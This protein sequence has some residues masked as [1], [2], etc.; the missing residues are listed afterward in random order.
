MKLDK[1]NDKRS[2]K[3][4]QLTEITQDSSTDDES[5]KTK[6][7]QR[8]EHFKSTHFNFNFYKRFRNSNLH[9]YFIEGDIGSVEADQCVDTL[10]LVNALLL[11]VP[12]QALAY[13]SN[14]YWDWIESELESCTDVSHYKYYDFDYIYRSTINSF[15]VLTFASAT[16]LSIAAFYYILRPKEEVI[17]SYWWNRGCR[18]VIIVMMLTSIASCWATMSLFL[19]FINTYPLSSSKFCEIYD[20]PS[21]NYLARNNALGVAFMS[22]I[23]LL[24][25]IVMI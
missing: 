25:M 6:V 21:K 22:F 17:F 7:M 2:Q 16:A 11:T 5:R 14:I 8:I 18:W 9:K 23:V 12:F 13:A 15:Y 24:S 20:E 3:P 10:A 1:I 19:S 4:N